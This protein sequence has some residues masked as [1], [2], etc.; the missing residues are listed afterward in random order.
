MIFG[1]FAALQFLPWYSRVAAPGNYG[2]DGW[3]IS[4]FI[5]LMWP[6]AFC[7]VSHVDMRY[8]CNLAPFYAFK[9]LHITPI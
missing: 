9:I 4:A 1:S 5:S 2:G 6:R 3:C 7:E 8:V